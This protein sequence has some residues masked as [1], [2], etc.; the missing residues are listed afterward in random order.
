MENAARD[1][2]PMDAR[3]L[4]EALEERGFRGRVVSIRRLPELKE[5]IERW[6]RQ[7]LLDERLHRI[8]LTRFR[9]SPDE[10]PPGARSRVVVANPQP[11]IRLTFEHEG[12][13]VETVI[14][15]T[16]LARV[17]D[18][19]VRAALE[20]MLGPSGHHVEDANVPLKLLAAS[21]GLARYGRNNVTYVPGFGSFHRLVAFFT[22]LPGD[23][24]GW[25]PPQMLDA[26]TRCT[27]CARLCPTGAIGSDR[28]LL[29]HD[30]CLTFLNEQRGPMPGWLDASVHH[31]LVGCM[32]C[33]QACPENRTLRRWFVQGP[34]F[35]EAETSLLLRG[36]GPAELPPRVAAK[37]EALDWP[38][39][40]LPV[41]AR[42]LRL[43]VAQARAGSS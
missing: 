18:G 5:A 21:S 4:L 27:A 6:R 11:P 41:L 37:L 32:R 15:P 14:P 16:Y 9:F 12:T 3:S 31:T 23:E 8:Y 39:V 1:E 7:G 42:N 38:D 43:L 34:S 26:C 28:F 2:G 10:V 35:D 33:Q 20:E 29:H 13:K 22:D 24:D 19:A 25:R 17:P 36:R 30:R 40:D